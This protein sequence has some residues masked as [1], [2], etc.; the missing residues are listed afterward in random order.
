MPELVAAADPGDEWW[1][2]AFGVAVATCL[3]A[4]GAMAGG[5]AAGTGRPSWRRRSAPAPVPVEVSHS[6][7]SDPV[8]VTVPGIM[9]ASGRHPGR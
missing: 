9:S 4:I 1:V 5:L 8:T 7:G 6:L 2:G 3:R